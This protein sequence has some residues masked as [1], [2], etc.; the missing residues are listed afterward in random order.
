MAFA[1]Q[2]SVSDLPLPIIAN[3]LTQLDS[4][5]D[6][7]HAVLSHRVFLEAFRDN[8]CAVVRHI[9]RSKIP[10]AVL[11]YALA[12]LRSSRLQEVDDK[13]VAQLLERL[14]IHATNSDALEQ[15][16]IALSIPE[17]AFLCGSYAAVESLCD[18]F[19]KDTAPR[20]SALMGTAH[21]LVPTQNESFRV[22][23]AYFRHQIMC[24]LF[25]TLNTSLP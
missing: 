1:M 6:L 16:V 3:A 24:N 12:L 23:R 20:L 10:D 7:Y 21:E 8:S 18:S 11:P 5:G 22:A 17:S 14:E 9:I 2:H 25:C 13:A 19:V 15:D 4:V